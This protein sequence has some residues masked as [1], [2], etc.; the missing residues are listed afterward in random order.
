MLD[1]RVAGEHDQRDVVPLLP[2]QLEELEAGES[3][4]PVVGDDQVD[5][6]RSPA[7]AAPAATFR[8]MIGEWP[9][10]SRVSSRIRPIA[11]SSST[12]RIVAISH[13]NY[14]VPPILN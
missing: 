4:H 9:A 8:A 12:H 14:I 7:P 6:A 11:G 13:V 1:R 10:R 5:A 3:R 2:K